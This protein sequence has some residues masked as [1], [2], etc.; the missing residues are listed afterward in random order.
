MGLRFAASAVLAVLPAAQPAPSPSPS[1]LAISL[2][3]PRAC[4]VVRRCGLPAA[5]CPA[6]KGDD[7]VTIDEPRCADV[8]MLAARGLAL[9]SAAGQRVYRFLGRRYRV[10]YLL[11]G[12]VPVSSERLSFLIDDLPLAARLLT[13]LGRTPY[14]AEW[15]D[16]EH[17]RFKAGR[18]K[19]L[20]GDAER[21]SGSTG[22]RRLFFY[23]NGVSELG[24][25]SLKGQALVEAQYGPAG[26]DG[27]HLGY[28][29]RVVATPSNAA[30]DVIMHMRLFRSIVRGRIEDIL[31][32]IQEAARVLDRTKGA[33]ILDSPQWSAAEKERIAEFLRLP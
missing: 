26:P 14:T 7:G 12:Q 18:G 21:V 17:T 15:L 2:L 19:G 8:R 9:D 6:P 27:R 29:I 10:V 23:G 5:G 24:P 25:W 22:E 32:D 20:H 31:E 28:R 1:P 11:D 3:D 30:V 33:G 16:A 13:R 4:A